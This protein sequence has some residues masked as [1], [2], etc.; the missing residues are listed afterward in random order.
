MVN[1]ILAAVRAEGYASGR[2]APR[3][4]DGRMTAAYPG[5][6][7]EPP[8]ARTREQGNGKRAGV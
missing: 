7:P 1:A 2:T 5:G 3:T 4:A 6:L 8:S